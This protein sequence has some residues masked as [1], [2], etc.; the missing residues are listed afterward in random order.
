M[1]GAFLLTGCTDGVPTTQ[2][3]GSA[4]PFKVTK[5][6]ARKMPKRMLETVNTLRAAEGLAPLAP[7]EALTAAAMAHSADMAAQQRPWHFGSDGSSPLDRVARAG[8]AGSFRGELL[9][10]S[11]EDDVTTINAWFTD[12]IT[13]KVLLDPE[14]NE[15]GFGW[16]QEEDT[17]K[18]WWTMVTGRAPTATGDAAS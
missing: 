7:S 8:Y 9:S 12:E 5:A 16:F 3:P 2:G 6:Q 18:L 13:R 11:F 17:G 1:T 15:V 14:A 4:A 10:E